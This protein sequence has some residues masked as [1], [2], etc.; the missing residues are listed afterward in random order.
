ME[1][2]GVGDFGKNMKIP[3]PNGEV[4]STK[5]RP[6]F[7][8]YIHDFPCC[9]LCIYFCMVV[10]NCCRSKDSVLDENTPPVP[11]KYDTDV[12]KPRVVHM[13]RDLDETT[14]EKLERLEEEMNE[15]KATLKK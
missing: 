8:S 14:V 7:Q 13:K 10:H 15:L 9:C 6:D 11:Q 3:S 2:G 5:K 4:C 1:V 12:T